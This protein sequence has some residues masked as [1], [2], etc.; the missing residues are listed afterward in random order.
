MQHKQ[1]D[2]DEHRNENKIAKS[3]R[4]TL[5]FNNDDADD[6]EDEEDD[7]DYYCYYYV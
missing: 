1:K 5:Y 7:D 4:V 2:K 3:I 6:D